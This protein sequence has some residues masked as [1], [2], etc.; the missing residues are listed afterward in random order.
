MIMMFMLGGVRT[1]CYFGGDKNDD[2]LL[3]EQDRLP[4]LNFKSSIAE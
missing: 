4:I 1:K 3:V 2:V